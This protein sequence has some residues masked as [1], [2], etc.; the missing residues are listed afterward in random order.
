LR[1]RALRVILWRIR[2]LYGCR[3][4]AVSPLHSPNASGLRSAIL[5]VYAELKTDGEQLE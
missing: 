5:A 1:K 3:A 4:I 2:K